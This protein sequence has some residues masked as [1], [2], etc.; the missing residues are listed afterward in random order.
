MKVLL[1]H[2]VFL[3]LCYLTVNFTGIESG[4]VIGHDR[5]VM[6]NVSL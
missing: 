6:R 4:D 2:L 3:L 5:R 1:L